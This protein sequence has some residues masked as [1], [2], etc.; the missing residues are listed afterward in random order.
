MSPV[1]RWRWWCEQ[2][3]RRGSPGSARPSAP[4]RL[5]WDKQHVWSDPRDTRLLNSCWWRGPCWLVPG[6]PFGLGKCRLHP[7]T[8]S[9][10]T[11]PARRGWDLRTTYPSPKSWC[12]PGLCSFGCEGS[13]LVCS[14]LGGRLLWPSW[15]LQWLVPVPPV[16]QSCWGK[17]LARE[18][19]PVLHFHRGSSSL[20]A[21]ERFMPLICP[22]EQ[23]RVRETTGC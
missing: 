17:R 1:R 8:A 16:E 6:R 7:G 20:A 11:V 12:C 23:E 9:S 15:C 4:D 18:Q 22:S 2:P 21:A 5:C 13:C 14:R 3:C 10:S 19:G